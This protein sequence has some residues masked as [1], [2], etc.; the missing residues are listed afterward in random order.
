MDKDASFQDENLDVEPKATVNSDS[1]FHD[2][3]SDMNVDPPPP[4]SAGAKQREIEEAA[5]NVMEEEE[6]EMDKDAAF[7]DKRKQMQFMDWN[8]VAC[9]CT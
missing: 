2:K 9:S 3:S 1:L 4:T 6:G 7:R 8:T 5:D